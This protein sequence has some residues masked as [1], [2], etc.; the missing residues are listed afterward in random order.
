ASEALP[1]RDAFAV[2]FF[3]SVGML[4]DPG[5]LFSSPGLVAGALGI[6]LAAKPAV[7]FLLAWAM[8][9][10]FRTAITVAIALAQIGEFS[11]ILASLGR[12]L[13]V[14]TVDANNALV[15]TSIVSIVL[16]PMLYRMIGPA[17]RWLA[18]QPR[19]RSLLNRSPPI[20][21]AW[22]QADGRSQAW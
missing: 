3:V 5:A 16:N 20:P 21:S 10:P 14:V 22:S 4:L 9:Y 2:L 7:A 13:G 12:G 8:R 6:V 19:I 1:M 18:H 17:E 15:A 11:F